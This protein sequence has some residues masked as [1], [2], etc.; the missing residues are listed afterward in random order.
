MKKEIETTPKNEPWI[1]SLLIGFA[2]G[3]FLMIEKGVFNSVFSKK[4][5][6][7]KKRKLRRN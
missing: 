3:I 4:I 6:N 5:M 1:A 2:Q 7:I